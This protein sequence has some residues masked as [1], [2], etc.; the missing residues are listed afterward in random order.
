[1]IAAL[2]SGIGAGVVVSLQ[3]LSLLYVSLGDG[4]AGAS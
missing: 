3:R 4:R 1:M 2:A